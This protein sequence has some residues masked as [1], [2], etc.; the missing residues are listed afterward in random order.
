MKLCFLFG[1]DLY[2]SVDIHRM[3]SFHATQNGL[4][5]KWKTT[6]NLGT[7]FQNISILEE[8]LKID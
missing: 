2:E 3:T 5:C 1:G 7:V 4:S 8:F 6:T